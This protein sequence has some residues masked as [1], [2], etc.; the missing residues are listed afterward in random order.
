MARDVADEID[1]HLEEKIDELMAAGL[2]RQAA[3]AAARRAFGNVTLVREESRD[4][5]RSRPLDDVLGDIR[6]ALRQL[7]RAPSFAAAAILTLAIGIGA[8]SAV[9][10][11]VNT[12]VL[13]PL[14]FPSP[15]RLVSVE[16]MSIRG[17]PHPD[18]LAYFTFFELRRAAV[19]ERIACYRDFGVTLTG[20]DLPVHLQAMMVSSDLFDLLGVAPALGRGFLAEEEAPGARVVVLSHEVWQ[21]QF[22]GDPAIVGRSITLD[23]EPNTVVGVAP[24]GF[25]YPIERRPIQIWTTLAR[26]ASS[27]TMQPITEQRGARLLNAVAR[28]PPGMSIDQAR[29]QLDGVTARLAAEYPDSNKNLPA[30]YVRPELHRLLG[31]ARGPILVLWGA[32]TL[33][34][35][36]A[37]AN[38]AN[39][40]LARTAD[41]RREF[42]VRVAIGGSRGRVI[43]QLL[44]ENLVI[45]LM[46]GTAAVV[47]AVGGVD[48]LFPL[49][50]DYMPRATEVSID[51]GVLAFTIGLALV[52]AVLV[53]V[54]P[55][56][57]ITQDGVRRLDARRLARKHRY[58]GARSRRAGRRP[59][60]HRSGVAVRR[61]R[62][63]GG[64]PESHASRPRLPPRESLQFQG[65]AFRAALLDRRAGRFHGPAA[66]TS[67]DGAG[68]DR[69]DPRTCRCR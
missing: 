28:L 7:R 30:T 9:F 52:T 60:R 40:L 15:D 1:L 39:M 41:R 49:I 29:A 43:R 55:A 51:G 44:T 14:P 48:L 6:Y 58:P 20:G 19:V 2:T 63:G 12:V 11:V 3:A 42:G 33:V 66:R 61:E 8:N 50:A 35:L 5:W 67:E 23:G 68:S 59:G 4:V 26:D 64:F 38:I 17:T 56:L 53:S 37:C 31:D 36:I 57:W 54:P 13:R 69:R 27:P 65:R 46:G 24:A 10:S 45:A 18:S 34:L 22:G 16:L 32:V 25:T 47:V 62:A 21:T